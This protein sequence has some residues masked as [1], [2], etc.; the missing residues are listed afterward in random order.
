MKQ[1]A[2]N[3]KQNMPSYSWR[4]GFGIV[5]LISG[6]LLIPGCSSKTVRLSQTSDELSPSFQETT[7]REQQ[8]IE[9][10]PVRETVKP[11]KEK[12]L[13]LEVKFKELS[14]LDT[15]R[16]SA[17]FTEE[18]YR[19]I[20]QILAK[21][22]GL[23]LV[24]APELE[25]LIGNNKLT[26]EYQ[27]IKVKTILD[28]ICAIFDVTWREEHS[29]LFIE[30]YVSRTIHLD[31]LSKIT[32]SSFSVGGD[33]LGGSSSSED[34]VSPLTGRFEIAGEVSDTVT[35]IYKNI[36]DTVGKRLED[37]GEF[38][39]NRQT[40]ILM[41]R[42][43][44]RLAAEL[45]DYLNVLR[46]KY[47]KQVLI[48]AQ[49]IEVS[50]REDQQMGIDWHKFNIYTG[51]DPLAG[52]AAQ[53]IIDLANTG[54]SRAPVYSLKV[55]SP[56]Y[57]LS[58][59]FSALEK[60]GNLKVL[61]KPRIKTMNGQSAAISVGQSVSYLK[62]L[63]KTVE[64][65]GDEQTVDISTEI[66]AIFDG[67]L[68]GVTPIIKEDNSV[69]LHVVPIKSEIVSLEQESLGAID[70]YSVAFPVVNLREISTIVNIR[71]KNIVVLGG[72]IMERTHDD[73]TG[74][75]L[76][77][78]LPYLGR[79]FKKEETSRENV[80]LVVILKIDVIE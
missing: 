76:L 9:K 79:I 57:I 11:E 7:I 68:L 59:V 20:F 80:E 73:E 62:S 14:P 29:T 30:P 40:G 39:L 63:T 31:F 26:A 74:V 60:Y 2:D 35:D 19:P 6:L 23:N 52:A 43:R 28:A 16:I 77:G 71:P 67:I 61:S 75:P 36:E 51:T 58:G 8:T 18:G 48:E 72:L 12:P 3:G 69:S 5:L 38:F 27:E 55:N 33:V 24:L 54:T 17:S 44:P 45:E 13:P 1:L 78:D 34:I 41:M 21:A 42:C 70:A 47:S 25:A 22:A 10:Q 46:K 15:Q 49:I 56:D 64:G 53:T 4:Y 37:N 32:Q 65:S 66:G 50:L